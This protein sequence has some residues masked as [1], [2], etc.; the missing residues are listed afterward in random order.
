MSLIS[1]ETVETTLGDILGHATVVSPDTMGQVVEKA[2][3]ENSRLAGVVVVDGGD[4]VGVVS[5]ANLLALFSHRIGTELYAKRPVTTM[6]NRISSKPLFLESDTTI[7]EAVDQGLNRDPSETYEPIVTKDSTGQFTLIHF[8]DLILAQSKVLETTK[9]VLQEKN[10]QV[11]SSIRY[12]ERI[13]TSM[14]YSQEGDLP[15]SI[16]RAILFRPRD[17]VSGDFY[18][19]AFANGLVYLTVADCT[20][21]GVPG[22]FMSLIGHGHLQ[23]MIVNEGMKDPAAI[24]TELHIRV[25]KS[26]RQESAGEVAYDGLELALVVIDA[27]AKTM[28]FAGAHRPIAYTDRAG[29]L[30][31]QKGDRYPIGGKQREDSRKFTNYSIPTDPEFT[32]YLFSDGYADQPDPANKKF[33]IKRLKDTFKH[34][35]GLNLKDKKAFLERA[36]DLYQKGIEQRDDIAIMAFEIH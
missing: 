31:I 4:L 35:A 13:Q 21:H 27:E 7:N 8:H 29:V 3:Q 36:L 18:W 10:Q 24:L 6:L 1:A 25:R 12:A 26:L 23:N 14:L 5:R 19:Q 33:G 30:T 15:E 17:I 16:K 20:G 22:A 2:L 28:Q 11:A 34:I 9:G 32:Y